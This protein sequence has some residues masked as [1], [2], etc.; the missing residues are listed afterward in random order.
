M[1]APDTAGDGSQFRA[2]ARS[3]SGEPGLGPALRR[4]WVG[5][6]RRLDEELTAAGFGD[7]ALPDAR[8]MRICS[9]APD[10]TISQIARELGITRQGAAKF[11]ASLRER[12]YVTLTAS[13]T[14]GREK[15]VTPT[16]RGVDYLSTQR[17]VARRIEQRLRKEIG[18][19]PFDNL[20]LLVAAL[21]GDAQ[22]RLRDYV[23]KASGM[24]EPYG[25]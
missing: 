20:Q 17:R 23:R 21:D 1:S 4:A 25:P 12:N 19:G 11:V 15:I 24:R 16:D 8:V 2:A 13:T 10:V 18:S 14:D 22:T 7:S 5:Y 6:R 9:R 3:R